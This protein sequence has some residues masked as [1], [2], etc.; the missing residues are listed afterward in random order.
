M[1]SSILTSLPGSSAYFILGAVVYSN[2]AKNTILSIPLSL[3]TR[4]GAVSK[5]VAAAMAQTVRGIA[6]TGIGIGIT[7]IA[8]PA[9][10]TARKPVG[11]VFISVATR[12][13]TLCTKFNFRGTRSS[14]RSQSALAALN[15]LK[16]LL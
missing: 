8:G 14:I 16:G 3:I 4:H 9:G 12:N 15:M 11:T 2:P 13:K 5:Q 7:G 10:G 6:K 1:L